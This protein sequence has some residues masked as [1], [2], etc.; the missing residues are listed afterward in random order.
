M[1]KEWQQKLPDFVR[2]LEEALY[3]SAA[4]KARGGAAG[5][6]RRALGGLRRARSARRDAR[7]RASSVVLRVH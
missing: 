6:F 5:G 4:T 7:G 2:R 1:T 3:R